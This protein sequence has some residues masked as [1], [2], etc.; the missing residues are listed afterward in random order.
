MG[1]VG[2]TENTEDKDRRQQVQRW[3]EGHTVNLRGLRYEVM[4]GLGWEAKKRQKLE[5][6]EVRNERSEREREVNFDTEG[7]GRGRH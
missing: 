5:V 4:K 1:S 6:L 3:E 2:G 7:Y